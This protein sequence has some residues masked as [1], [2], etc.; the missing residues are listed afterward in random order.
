PAR[1]VNVEVALRAVAVR[2]DLHKISCQSLHAGPITVDAL[3]DRSLFGGKLAGAICLAEQGSK[4]VGD[5]VVRWRRLRR[6]C[7]RTECLAPNRPLGGWRSRWRCATPSLRD[8]RTRGGKRDGLS[9]CR[10]REAGQ[11]HGKAQF[12]SRLVVCRH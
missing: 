2:A 7:P 9:E 5:W 10:S 6:L 4:G 1:L 3:K 8:R 11:K 12:C